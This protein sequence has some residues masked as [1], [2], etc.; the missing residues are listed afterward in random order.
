M[1]TSKNEK[2]VTPSSSLAT[3]RSFHPH[4]KCILLNRLSHCP[5]LSQGKR[6]TLHRFTSSSTSSLSLLRSS[7]QATLRWGVLLIS[8]FRKSPTG[9]KPLKFLKLRSMNCYRSLKLSESSWMA[10]IKDRLKL[11]Y[12]N[13]VSFVNFL[14]LNLH[15][16]FSTETIGL[17]SKIY[18]RI[19]SLERNLTTRISVLERKVDMKSIVRVQNVTPK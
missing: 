17:F 16:I 8:Q 6:K 15:L 14:V 11:I 12:C 1:Q 13:K 7:C 4:L 5:S 18:Q 19:D 9:L 2:Q 10:M 3:H